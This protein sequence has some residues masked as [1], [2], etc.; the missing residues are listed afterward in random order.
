VQLAFFLLA[1]ALLV[2][3]GVWRL[4]SCVQGLRQAGVSLLSPQ[5]AGGTAPAFELQT[6]D[7][8]IVKLSDF[9]GRPVLIN[10]WATWCAPC[11]EELP[12]L[13]RLARELAETPVNLVLISV[14]EGWAPVSELA[15]EAGEEDQGSPWSL[16][17]RILRGE[18]PGVLSLLDPSE[19]VARSY[20]TFKYPETYLV[21][22]SGALVR[23]FVG[24]KA[25]GHPRAVEAL[26][27]LLKSA[28][29]P[30]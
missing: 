28:A 22:G 29:S 18:S 25:W 2:A 16:V 4:E 15:Q 1:M 21:D 17:A 12:H 23:R 7:G 3:T 8:R 20:G 11:R 24:P 30:R 27:E 5:P 14:D 13:A 6:L 10:F 19:R 26:R 9:G